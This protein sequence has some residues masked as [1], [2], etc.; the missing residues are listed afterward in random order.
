MYYN[1][2]AV[3]P[4]LLPP[5]DLPVPL[6]EDRQADRLD[7]RLPEDDLKVVGSGAPGRRVRLV[8]DDLEAE[9]VELLHDLEVGPEPLA[10]LVELDADLPHAR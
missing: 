9:L 2:E 1:S 5:L 10:G 8:R 6:R 7:V 3:S 4:V